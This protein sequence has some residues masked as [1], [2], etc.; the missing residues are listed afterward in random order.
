[1]ILTKKGTL[2]WVCG[3]R[4][5]VRKNHANITKELKKITI[6]IFF[7]FFFFRKSSLRN[8]ENRIF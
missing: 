4:L 1:M 8:E 3:K 7:F 6:K 5:K 2:L